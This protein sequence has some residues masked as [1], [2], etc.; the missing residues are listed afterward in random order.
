MPPS[1]KRYTFPVSGALCAKVAAEVLW[2]IRPASRTPYN[3]TDDCACALPAAST[4]PAAVADLSF[5]ESPELV[6]GCVAR[7]GC[8]DDDWSE[9]Y[10]EGMRLTPL[11]ERGVG[12]GREE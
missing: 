12:I 4:S 5:I 6:F 2:Y 7:R 1:L 3:V 10:A 8:C 9:E 11:T